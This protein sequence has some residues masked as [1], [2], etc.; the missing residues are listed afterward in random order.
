MMR[1]GFDFWRCALLTGFEPLKNHTRDS[2]HSTV[3]PP[4][5]ARRNDGRALSTRVTSSSPPPHHSL[6]LLI[7][8]M[9]SSLP[10][11]ILVIAHPDDESMFFLPTL[12]RLAKQQNAR[13]WVLCLSNGNYNGLGRIREKE[14]IQAC[15]ILGV[16]QQWCLDIFKLQDD[17][18]SPWNSCNVAA[19]MDKTLTTTITPN[20]TNITI[21]TFDQGGVSGHANH[22]DTFRGVQYWLSTTTSKTLRQERQVSGWKLDTVTNPIMKYIPLVWLPLLLWN[23]WFKPFPRQ[24]CMFQPLLVWRAMA[25]HASQFVWYRRLSVL[26]SRY[27]YYNTWSEIETTTTKSYKD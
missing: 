16:E 17:P 10:L 12:L 20:D 11:Y 27:T 5:F 8:L 4:Y 9:S 21:L 6:T 18:A 19:A 14:F 22:V 3:L 7:L 13:I 2:I 24:Y 15:R 26:F 23:T 1:Y 25:A